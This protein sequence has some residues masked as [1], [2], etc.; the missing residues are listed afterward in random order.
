MATLLKKKWIGNDQID[1]EKIKLLPGQTLRKDDGAGGSIDVI[2]VLEAGTAQVQTN[3]TQEISDRTSQGSALSQDIQDEASR[4]LG[5]EAAIR[6]E[7]ASADANLQSQIDAISGGG[8]GSL[9]A[10][11]S[12]LDTTQTAV[13]LNY[14]GSFTLTPGTHF[15]AN[16]S[17]VRGAIEN[18]DVE[19]FNTQTIISQ[20]VF[21]RTSAVS[22]LQNQIDNVL[23]NVDGAALDSLT[24]VVSAFQ[25]ADAS[26]N[27]AITSLAA[28]ASSGLA[29]ETA[30]RIASDNALQ[31]EIDAE[32]IARAAADT[33]LQNNITSEASARSAADVVL[34]GNIDDLDGY[35]QVIRADLDQEVLDREAAVSAEAS[36]R[37]SADSVLSG[38]VSVLESVVWFKEK[39]SISNGQISVSLAHTPE[40]NSMTAFVDRLAIH[41]GSSEDYTIS[42]STMTFLNDLVSP[43]QSQL[44]NGDTIYVKYQYKV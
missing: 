21:D 23:S 25:A 19:I 40:A 32:E 5:Q 38:R 31:G 13:G 12:E 30:S 4:A 37:T 3:L 8:S 28:S 16:S 14:D 17:S 22:N 27:G 11:Q 44:G 6:S 35:A 34:Q 7:F 15:I 9:S 29:S 43:G 10:L 33:T 2:A 42:G 36:A 26:L 24:E 41:Q 1:G 18:L 20:E 39:F